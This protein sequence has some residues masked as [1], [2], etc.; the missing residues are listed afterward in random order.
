MALTAKYADYRA[1][2][3]FTDTD[4]FWLSVDYAF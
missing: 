2:T 1:D 3:L 4:K